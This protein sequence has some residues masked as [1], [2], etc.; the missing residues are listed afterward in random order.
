MSFKDPWVCA[1]CRKNFSSLT[2]FDE[3]RVG[4]FTDEHPLY[5]RSCLSDKELEDRGHS[6]YEGVWTTLS[7]ERAEEVATKRAEHARRSFVGRAR[8]SR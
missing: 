8:S 3:H 7:A 1:A 6:L 4:K 5:G 2:L